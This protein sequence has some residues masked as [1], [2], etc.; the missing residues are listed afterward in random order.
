MIFLIVP[1]TPQVKAFESL[2]VR[3]GNMGD[4]SVKLNQITIIYFCNFSLFKDK[5][6][7]FLMV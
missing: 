2:G 3:L 6:Y 5:I 7:T 4:V 1:N